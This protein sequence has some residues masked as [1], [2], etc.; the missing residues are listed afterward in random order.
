MRPDISVHASQ[1]EESI[2]DDWFW[3]LRR[4]RYLVQRYRSHWKFRCRT[5]RSTYWKTRPWNQ[6]WAARIN[7]RTLG[8]WTYLS[9]TYFLK[10]RKSI[11]LNRCYR[12]WGIIR[13]LIVL[14]FRRH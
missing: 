3:E 9:Q 6:I 1:G 11:H 14:W 5:N 13:R 2:E 4:R 10:S 12:L 8:I 7:W